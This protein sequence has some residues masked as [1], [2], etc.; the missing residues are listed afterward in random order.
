MQN[1]LG[2]SLCILRWNDGLLYP[3]RKE[4]YDLYPFSLCLLSDQKTH[5]QTN[6]RIYYTP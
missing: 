5:T 1:F 4:E 2:F 6:V 3:K